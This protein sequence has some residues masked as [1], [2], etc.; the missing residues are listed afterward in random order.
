[1]TAPRSFGEWYDAVEPIVCGTYLKTPQEIGT[2]TP[3]EIQ[4]MLDGADWVSDREWERALFV[5]SPDA[6][7][8]G[9]LLKAHYPRFRRLE[10]LA[11]KRQRRIRMGD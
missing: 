9:K 8:C 4:I 3:A 6:G 7:L 1:M 2:L 10:A 11:A 5:R